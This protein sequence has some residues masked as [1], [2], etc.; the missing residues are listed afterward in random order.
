MCGRTQC[1]DTNDGATRNLGLVDAAPPRQWVLRLLDEICF[2]LCSVQRAFSWVSYSLWMIKPVPVS[3]GAP[4][5]LFDIV[6]PFPNNSVSR[7]Y[8]GRLRLRLPLTLASEC[9]P[10]R[11]LSQNDE[12]SDPVALRI[13][14]QL[15]PKIIHDVR[16]TPADNWKTDIMT[17]QHEEVD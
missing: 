8:W 4:F 6:S 3:E 5:Q 14:C 7:M 13:H 17:E 10:T 2:E 11:L 12:K 15:Y 16:H 9:T 1:C